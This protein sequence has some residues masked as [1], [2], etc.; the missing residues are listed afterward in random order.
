[1][2]KGGEVLAPGNPD[3]PVQFVD[4]R[5]LAQWIVQATARRL[6]GPYNATGPDYRLN[7]QQVLETCHIVSDS[8]AAFTW[9]S[10]EFLLA[11]DVTPFTEMPLWVPA[12]MVGFGTFDIQKAVLAELSFR[13]L[14]DTVGDTMAWQARRPADWEWQNGLAPEREATLLQAW[15]D[16]DHT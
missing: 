14:T 1:V 13:P 6:V 3:A 7:M 4:V 9:V 11:H 16:G 15:H 10:E 5:D 12:E 8:D 2:A